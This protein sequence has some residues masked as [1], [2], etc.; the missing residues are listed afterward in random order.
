[1]KRAEWPVDMFTCLYSQIHG[2]DYT[3]FKECIPKN[4]KTWL[5]KSTNLSTKSTPKSS[6]NNL[7]ISKSKHQND[8]NSTS[9]C[10]HPSLNQLQLQPFSN[11][12]STTIFQSSRHQCR[13]KQ[14]RTWPHHRTFDF[15]TR[16][17]SM[18]LK[19]RDST[20][21]WLQKLTGHSPAAF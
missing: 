2:A 14:P 16:P 6:Q 21:T 19:R 13:P 17:R 1:M 5:S 11:R 3:N 10:S 20:S 12:L 4:L 18:P 9:N 7:Q 15:R 8:P